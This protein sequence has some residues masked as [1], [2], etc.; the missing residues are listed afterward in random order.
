MRINEEKTYTMYLSVEEFEL[1]HPITKSVNYQYILYKDSIT[2][3]EE[4]II[5]MNEEKLDA[6]RELLQEEKNYQYYEECNRTKANEIMYLLD[7]I[8]EELY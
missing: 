7:D 5:Q 8:Y 6:V 4:Y 3:T 1:M 2:E